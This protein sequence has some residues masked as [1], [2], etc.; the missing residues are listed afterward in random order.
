MEQRLSWEVKR[1]TASQEI[2]HIIWNIKV[3][4]RIHKL[5]TPVLTLSQIN[6]VHAFTSH[7]L[8]IHLNIILL[9]MP[10]SPKWSLSLRFHHQNPLHNST[11]PHICYMP[12]HSILLNFITWTILGERYRSLS[13]SLCSLLHSPVPLSLL[14]PNIL[15][16][17]LFS[18]TLSLLEQSHPVVYWF[19]I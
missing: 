9:S 17:N 5:L 2:P 3:H 10:G 1:F 14:G 11:L 15:L 18:N 19:Y 6:P 8:K 7:F 4:Y 16:Y 13:S 12:P